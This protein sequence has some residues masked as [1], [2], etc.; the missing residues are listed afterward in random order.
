MH[1]AVA[2]MLDDMR[3]LVAA[4]LAL[5]EQAPA[6]ELQKVRATSAWIHE[7]ISSL[8]ADAP[9]PEPTPADQHHPSTAATT[10]TAAGDTA[11]AQ[12]QPGGQPPPPPPP[13]AS[14]A[15]PATETGDGGPDY[16]Y[17]T[18]RLTALLYSRAIAQRQPFSRTV[19]EEEFRGVCTTAWRVPLARWR[20]LLGVFT[21]VLLPLVAA[22]TVV[23]SSSSAAADKAAAGQRRFVRGMLSAGLLQMGLDDWAVAARAM[24]AALGLQRWLGAAGACCAAVAATAG[25]PSGDDG[26]GVGIG[27][28]E[29]AEGSRPGRGRGGRVSGSGSGSVGSGSGDGGGRGGEKGEEQ[30]DDG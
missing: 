21:W 10:T 15:I 29:A 16:V 9:A 2:R 11:T 22:G 8:P 13:P 23:T 27:G 17:Q 12:Q 19:S 6:K 24:E 28:G 3:F 20:Q 1:P 14:I 4:V 26:L 30:D 7:R 5:P 18:V 25:R